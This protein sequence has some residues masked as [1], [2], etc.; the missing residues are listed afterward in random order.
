MEFKKAAGA[1]G[2][3]AAPWGALTVAR[4]VTGGGRERR[5]LGFLRA[6]GRSARRRGCITGPAA[7]T[8]AE[9]GYK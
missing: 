6:L 5:V 2:G 9:A 3:A 7:P 8:P 4:W 1:A